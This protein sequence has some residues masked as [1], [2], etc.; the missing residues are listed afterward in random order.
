MIPIHSNV[1]GFKY[2][3]N[4]SLSYI[5]NNYG[6][7][8]FIEIAIDNGKAIFAP[9]DADDIIILDLL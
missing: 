1:L 2:E 8:A 5:P 3:L 9:Y 7:E 6:N 4:V